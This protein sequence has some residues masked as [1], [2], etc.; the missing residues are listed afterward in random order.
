MIKNALLFLFLLFIIQLP[1][2]SH[3]FV[4]TTGNNNN[5]GTIDSPW[6]TIQYGLDQITA[7]DTLDIRGGVYYEKVSM[8]APLP[9]LRLRLSAVIRASRLLLMVQAWYLSKTLYGRFTMKI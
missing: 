9:N 4:S 6:R 3:F 8:N 7:G 5:S 1:A 2:Q